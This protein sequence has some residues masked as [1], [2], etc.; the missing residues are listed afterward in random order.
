MTSCNDDEL[1]RLRD[2]CSRMNDEICQTL[3][4]VLGYPWFKDDQGNFPDATEENGVCVGDHVAE[5]LAIE[6][7]DRI[8][9]LAEQL[10]E[11]EA[12][13]VPLRKLRDSPAWEV[14]RSTLSKD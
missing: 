13:L 4:R 6:A 1:V 9:Q 2:A 12:E 5:S 14:I 10:K 7:A 8:S 3:G 11:A